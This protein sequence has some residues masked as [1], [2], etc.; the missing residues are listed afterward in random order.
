MAQNDSF[1]EFDG[2]DSFFV[3]DVSNKLDVNGL[4][5]TLETWVYP[6]T[7]PID[8]TFPALISRKYSFELY[9]RNTSDNLGFGIVAFSGSGTGF[10]S[11]ASLHSST[12][13]MTLNEWHH[14]AVSS[15]Y[16]DGTRTTRL[17]L[18]G[19]Q[20]YYSS[21]PD[22]SLDASVSSINIGTRYDGSYQRYIDHCAMDEIRYS[23]TARY[24]SNFTVN[25]SSS[26]HITDANTILLYHF[27][28]NT[29]AS[30]ANDDDHDFDALLRDTPNKATWRLWNYFTPKNLPF[31][32]YDWKGTTN[33]DW[34]TTS[35]WD[36]NEIPTNGIDVII[37]NLTNDPVVN[38]AVGTPATCNNLLVESG[39]ILTINVDKAL[40]VSGNLINDGLTI[41]SDADGTGSLII[42]GTHTNNGTTTVERYLTNYGA[43]GDSKYHFLS[44][45]VTEQSI[46]PSFVAASPASN[47]DFYKYDEPTN[48]WINTKAVGGA[49][50]GDF[51]SNFFVGRG[52][53][54]TYP[55]TPVTKEFIGTLNSYPDGLPLEITCTNTD[56]NGWN[57]I[58]NPYASALDWNLVDDDLGDGMDNALYY[59]DA[60]AENYRYYI[61]LSGETGALGSGSRYIPAMQGF[62]VHAETSGNMTVSIDNTQQVHSDQDYY[63]NSDTMDD[64]LVLK[65]NRDE[66]EDE[67]TLFFYPDASNKFDGSFDAYKLFSYSINMPQIYSLNNDLQLAINTLKSVSENPNISIGFK[68]QVAGTFEIGAS[69]FESFVGSQDVTLEDTY[70]NLLHNFE[71]SGN[72]IYYSEIGT[73]DNRFILHFGPTGINDADI[74]A[75]QIQI[76]SSNNTIQIINNKN[77]KGDISIVNLFGQVVVNYSLVGNSKQQVNFIAQPGLYIVNVKTDSGYVISKKVIIK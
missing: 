36:R 64:L 34:G 50:N 48:Y 16:V 53:L 4:D 27:N 15:T 1:L 10:T 25:P 14:I 76:W 11:E 44:S 17:F 45:P 52:Y 9:F 18:D 43:V 69:G 58:G 3:T 22:F 51:E 63:K 61:Q 42:N 73:Y 29:G 30:I 47:V 55:N 2:N 12:Q 26:E 8:G 33:N 72:Y 41:E 39:A 56:D 23:K 40:T 7:V 28:E 68:T 37:P 62:M 59:Y 24:T 38:E 35:N 31:S 49:W 32:S 21:D 74:T 65:V 13:Y 67:T 6:T 60:D 70:L 71:T 20:L 46:R 75:N 66:Y 77:L 54:V 19:T 57:L 5:W